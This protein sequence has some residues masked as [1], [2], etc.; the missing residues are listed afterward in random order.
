MTYEYVHRSEVPSPGLIFDSETYSIECDDDGAADETNLNDNAKS[1]V[2]IPTKEYAIHLIHMVKFHCCQLFHLYDEQEFMGY[3][4]AFYA[5]PPPSSTPCARKERLWYIHFLLLLA[6]GKAFTSRKDRGRRPPGAEFFT[7]AIE[8]LPSTVTLSR[9]P[10]M[11]VEVL[12]CLA[13]YIH[14]IDYRM[15]AYNYVSLHMFF[16][17]GAVTENLWQIGQAIRLAMCNGMH[18]YVSPD[19]VGQ[20]VAQRYQKIWSTVYVLDCEMTSWQGLPP[21]V[22]SE[23]VCTSWPT[24]LDDP[25]LARALAMRIK[26]SRVISR[27]NKCM[28]RSA[29]ST[30]LLMTDAFPL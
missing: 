9:E 6:F 8:L 27:V 15:S 23:D 4:D 28:E 13:L 24:S 17:K 10:I 1:T 26:L 3:L 7:R 16:P 18:G 2:S 11:S 5:R 21:S 12:M 22:N 14:C 30:L 29:M 20:D 19:Q 25:G